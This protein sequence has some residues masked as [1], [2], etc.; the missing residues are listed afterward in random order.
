MQQ[1]LPPAAAASS[2]S[3]A[4]TEAPVIIRSGTII[5]R[6]HS[7]S[8]AGAWG[9]RGGGSRKFRG[10]TVA[11][12]VSGRSGDLGDWGRDT[13]RVETACYGAAELSTDEGDRRVPCRQRRDD[14]YTFNYADL[15][16]ISSRREILAK[17]RK[18]AYHEPLPHF[19]TPFYANISSSGN[20]SGACNT[21]YY[22]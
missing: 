16:A 1:P 15:P 13:Q 3:R 18:N 14:A 8:N 2:L 6:A 11:E 9:L 20:S 19:R 10:Q 17:M 12:G 22:S 5:R 4:D 7:G 21:L